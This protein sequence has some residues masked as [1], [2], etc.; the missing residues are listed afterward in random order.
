MGSSSSVVTNLLT[1]LS[2]F[3]PV[4]LIRTNSSSG[5]DCVSGDV[6]VRLSIE[7]ICPNISF[8]RGIP[9]GLLNIVRTGVVA[10]PT[11]L[12]IWARSVFH[13]IYEERTRISG[14]GSR[15]QARSALQDGIL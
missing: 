6:P 5:R 13:R 1:F 12:D 9:F 10:F 7:L 3:P 2:G 14:F 11:G 8:A 4:I 15:T